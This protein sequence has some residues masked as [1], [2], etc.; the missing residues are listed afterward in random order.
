MS[1][2]DRF[3]KRI[4]GKLILGGAALAVIALFSTRALAEPPTAAT[5][6]N[7]PTIDSNGD[8]KADAWDRNADGKADA[9]DANGDGKPDSWDDDFDG[10]ADPAPKPT[11]T[12]TPSPQS[13]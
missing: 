2:A 6:P 1:I 10:V 3:P 5:K 11:P 9:W 12:A 13:R 7:P 4:P 8:G